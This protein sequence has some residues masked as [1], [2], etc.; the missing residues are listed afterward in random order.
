MYRSRLYHTGRICKDLPR[1]MYWRMVFGFQWCALPPAVWQ[2]WF[3]RLISLM[4]CVMKVKCCDG[5]SFDQQMMKDLLIFSL[6]GSCCIPWSDCW[7]SMCPWA[8]LVPMIVPACPVLVARHG[9]TQMAG[10]WW[11]ILALLIPSGNDSHIYSKWPSRNNGD[12][13]IEYGGS[14]Y[15]YVNVYQ[16]VDVVLFI[17]WIILRHPQ[18]I[19]GGP[20]KLQFDHTDR[21]WWECESHTM[22]VHS[23]TDSW[24]TQSWLTFRIPSKFG[25]VHYTVIFIGILFRV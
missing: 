22:A 8:G 2:S 5:W 4:R 24:Q 19:L 12:F 14:F 9:V 10:K 18:L 21:M 11:G 17:V 13:P 6:I 3:L 23:D 1:P 25:K 20:N 16:S 15:R 7:W